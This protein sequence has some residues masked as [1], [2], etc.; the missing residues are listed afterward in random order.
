MASDSVRDVRNGAL[1]GLIATVPMTLV[2]LI[3]WGL[4]PRREQYPLPPREITEEMAEKA[5]IEAKLTDNQLTVASLFS[6]FA[7]GAMTGSI[8]AVLE[9]KMRGADELKGV[10]AGLLVWVGSYLG[11]LPALRI[12]KPATQHPW[13]RNL[14]MI[15][16]HLVWGVTLGEVTQLLNSKNFSGM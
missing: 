3:G 15:V 7:Y 16:A 12:L 8:Y 1:A 5:N 13:R 9:R 11:W 2:M 10:V 4:L 6:H 14:L